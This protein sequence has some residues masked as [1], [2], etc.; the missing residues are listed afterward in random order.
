MGGV[1]VTADDIAQLLASPPPR[2]VPAHVV[3]AAK[4]GG[5]SWITALFG[6]F[7]GGFGLV[8]VVIFFPWR[9]WDDWRLAA[10]SAQRVQG[11][12]TEVRKSNM[13]INETEVM[14]YRFSY[15]PQGGQQRQGHCYTT[16]GQWKAHEQV[17]VRYLDSNPNLACVEGARLTKGGGFGAFVII[18]PL[19]GFGLVAWFCIQRGRTG[20]VLREGIAIEVDVRSVEA[21]NMRV[22]YETVYRITLASP[23]LPGGQPV[24]IKRVNKPDVNLATQHALQQ[25][26]VFILYDPRKPS[27][28]IFPEALI[29]P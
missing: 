8:F 26:P 5:A 3:R 22:N 25:Q 15:T 14:E 4:G 24:T 7:F 18:F 11:S 17:T 13:S 19:V 27:R 20:R 6:L 16:G 9:F 21:T 28:V 1:K 12:I 23:T 10:D 29:D 2:R